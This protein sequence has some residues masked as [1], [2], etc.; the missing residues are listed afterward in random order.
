MYPAA[1][2]NK[3]EEKD[4]DA[5][6]RAA[7]IRY[8]NPFNAL[9]H[10]VRIGPSP[11][12]INNSYLPAAIET[13]IELFACLAGDNLRAAGQIEEGCGVLC[14]LITRRRSILSVMTSWTK[15]FIKEIIL[16]TEIP[17]MYEG[18]MARSRVLIVLA[19]LR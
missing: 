9:R 19:G 2:T 5:F 10:L 13:A 12:S 1:T 4:N 6:M 16:S 17:T 8:K 14:T 7:R 15:L 3:S 18:L 11:S